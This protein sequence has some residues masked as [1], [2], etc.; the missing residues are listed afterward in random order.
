M[1]RVFIVGSGPSAVHFALTILQKGYAVV[2][3]DVGRTGPEP[4]N[5][6]DSF[7]Q[8]KRNLSDPI[9]YFLGDR[10]EAVRYPTDRSEYYGFPPT[11]HH[12]FGGVE[13]FQVRARGFEPLWSFAQGGL[14][15]AWTG[16]VYPLNDAEL[17]DFPWSYDD[18][19]PYYERVAERIGI[20]GHTDDLSRFM[21]VQDSLLEPLE[22]DEHSELLFRAYRS[23]RTLVNRQTR[24]YMGRS[25]IATTTR[26]M[27]DRRAC[28][29]LGR[30]L[31]GCPTES[32][33]TPRA[34]LRECAT[35][36]AFRYLSGRWVRHFTV[37]RGRRITDLAP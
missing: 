37:D 19:A 28:S 21:P 36:D 26:D 9:G 34:T 12:V 27:D 24:C 2:M 35:F 18:L 11:K 22:L 14:A 7:S 31:W 33:Y 1:K 32:L 20:S 3:L 23:R 25:R 10:F 13:S 17:A 6:H 5:P 16:G 4:V 15:E 8:L 29:Y 30:C